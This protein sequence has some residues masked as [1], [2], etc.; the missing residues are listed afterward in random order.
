M[1][2]TLNKPKNRQTWPF[3]QG[4]T[5]VSSHAIELKFLGLL[6]Q[7]KRKNH[8]EFQ[9]FIIIFTIFFDFFFKVPRATVD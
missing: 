5:S 9:A 8:F 2:L 4:V 3:L 6:Q 7:I 1:R